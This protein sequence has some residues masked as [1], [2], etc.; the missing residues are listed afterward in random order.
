MIKT[1]T[2]SDSIGEMAIPADADYGIHTARAVENFPI[3]GILLRHYPEFVQSLAMVKKAAA[4]ANRDLGTL[5]P[6][7]ASAIISACDLIISGDSLN[8]FVSIIHNFF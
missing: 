6:A 5:E 4:M 1:R 3:T 8:Q 2:E 7:I